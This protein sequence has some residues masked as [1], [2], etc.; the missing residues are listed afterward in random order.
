M[1]KLL[2]HFKKNN[3]TQF[4]LMFGAKIPQNAAVQGFTS[5]FFI[6]MNFSSINPKAEEKTLTNGKRTACTSYP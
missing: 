4:A 6:G 2:Y 1:P 5:L 3:V